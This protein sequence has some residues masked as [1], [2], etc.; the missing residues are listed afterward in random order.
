[1]LSR[2]EFLKIGAMVG[3]GV[4]L[5]VGMLEKA[6]AFNLLGQAGAA[7]P[8]LLTKYV[9]A[10]PGLGVMPRAK[11]NYY[12]VAVRQFASKLHRDIPATTT[13]GYRPA[14]WRP[15]VSPAN[16]YLGATFVERQ[17]HP[18]TVK[19]INNLVDGNGRPIPHPL[20]VDPSLHWAAPFGDNTLAGPFPV[21]AQG[22]STFDYTLP[23]VPIVT[24]VHGGE[25]EPSADG[26]PEAW[27]TPRWAQKGAAFK[28]TDSR[29]ALT[30]PPATLWYH[31][32]ALGLTRLNVYMG[33]AGAFLV[34]NPAK[35]PKGLP[36][37][38]YDIPL[39][40][41]DRM[42]DVNGQLFFPAISDNPT[43][44]PFWVP[45]FFGD[46]IL[47]NGKV[48]PYLNVEP[49]A[50]RFRVLD[51]ANARFFRMWLEDASAGT[52]GPAFKQIATDGG[53]LY[54]PVTLNDPN[55]ATPERLVVGPGERAEI[56]IDFSGYA[57]KTLLLRNDA[58]S[59]F[60]NGDPIDQNT[61][62]QV[63]QFR[64]ASSTPKA[65]TFPGKPLNPAL[66]KFPTLKVALP[67]KRRI[68]T[69]NEFASPDG[70]LAA[71]LNLTK[72]MA[73]VTET[74]RERSTEVWHV[75][76]TTEDA[77]PIHV[78]LVQFQLVSRQAFNVDAY[79][80]AFTAANGDQPKSDASYTEVSPTPYLLGTPMPPRANERG[81]KD[82]VQMLPGEV[83]TIV[84]R[85]APTEH[86]KSVPYT[87]N[88]TKSPGYVWH[89]HIL[90]HEDNEMMRPYR[91]RPFSSKP[92]A[93]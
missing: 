65:F 62:G 84:M 78:H 92:A 88:P 90:D 24:H 55:S 58:G 41:Q 21:D 6:L 15:G 75:A 26:H 2:R 71:F 57:G 34:T 70:P 3:A 36:S 25:Q 14:S 44:H 50:Y 82:T 48:W 91:V 17:H 46:H 67:D 47:V 74:P 59:P 10:L 18:I 51:G 56:V 89:C 35:E 13:W 53:Y 43:V 20:P 38:K 72:W 77:H 60:P 73:P 4:M 39:V 49:R 5:P 31:D 76:N 85:F 11:R 79:L 1:M 32:H 68:M 64:V 63:M 86:T 37:G 33:L 30:Q 7:D 22:Q 61:T 12:E 40:I 9:D 42:L 29:Y 66:A 93:R 52:P 45:E 23:A 16:T 54:R 83:T 87:F 81:W 69:L 28:S 8:T 27:F 19:W 80:A